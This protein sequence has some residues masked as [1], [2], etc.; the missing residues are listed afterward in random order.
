MSKSLAWDRLYVQTQ[1]ACQNTE[2]RSQTT[3]ILYI[4]LLFVHSLDLFPDFWLVISFLITVQ[5]LLISYLH[6]GVVIANPAMWQKALFLNGK[7]GEWGGGIIVYF[8]EP[9]ATN[10]IE[11]E[12]LQHHIEVLIISTQIKYSQ[13]WWYIFS[14]IYRKKTGT[15]LFVIL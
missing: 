12:A 15:H 2:R 1:R 5:F 14:S 11:F 3:K 9:Y 7:F 6:S 8:T 13:L 4:N 10:K